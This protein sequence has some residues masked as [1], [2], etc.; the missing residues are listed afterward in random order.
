MCQCSI[1]SFSN[2]SFFL[3]HSFNF[4]PNIFL[5]V[6]VINIHMFA[7]KLFE[8]F[9]ILTG[10][11]RY[12]FI[13][14]HRV[15]DDPSPTQIFRFKL[16]ICD[17][18]FISKKV[19]CF[20]MAIFIVGIVDCSYFPLAMWQGPFVML[21]DVNMIFF[22]YLPSKQHEKIGNFSSSLGYSLIFEIKL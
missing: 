19:K 17:Y 21:S 4:F 12:K 9:D 18:F 2:N 7:S 3:G 14:W 15:D 6:R 1:D 5:E 16:T 11:I 13:N 20:E 8:S 10:Q 22:D